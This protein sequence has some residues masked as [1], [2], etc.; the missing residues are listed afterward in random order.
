MRRT[1]ACLLSVAF[2]FAVA[3]VHRAN[4][5]YKVQVTP[6]ESARGVDVTVD[7]QPFTS[8]IWP[9]SLTKPVL[10]PIVSPAGEVVTRG[11]PLDPHPGER[12]DHPHQVGLWF[13]Y[14][15]VNGVDFWN[16]STAL[17]SAERAKMGTIV[18]RRIIRSE[19]GAGRGELEIE[20]QWLLPDGRPVLNEDTTFIFRASNGIR[21]IDRISRLTATGGRVAFKDDK[22]GVV[23]MR[24]ATWLEQPEAHS[25]VFTD[26]SGKA[27]E[28]PGTGGADRT[29]EYISSEG[30]RGDA[31]WGTRGR[32]CLL[33]G[34]AGG[35]GG[36]ETTLAIIDHPSNPGFPTHWHARGY[37]LFAANPLGQKQLS[38]GKSELNFSIEPGKSATLRYRVLIISG[39]PSADQIEA[40]YSD[41]AA[42]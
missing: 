8:Y 11:F 6:N 12:I 38:G 10:Y 37:G 26:S 15:N 29:G 14:G 16:N 21:S 42:K 20:A 4:P 1:W 28:V 40:Q 31:V 19:S 5:A 18:H 34:R 41:F 32:W 9:Q 35:G 24:V 30:I 13:S 23:G 7:G 25:Q 27:T 2:V 33:H 3:P 36:S 39:P 22:E 17:E